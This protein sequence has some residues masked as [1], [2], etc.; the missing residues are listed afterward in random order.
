[1]RT[2]SAKDAKNH[3]G[4]LLLEAQKAPVTIEKNGR[5]V[6]VL[7]SIEEHEAAEKMKLE[8]LRSMI[9]EADDAI[10]RGEEFDWTDE[11]RRRFGPKERQSSPP[12]NPRVTEA[13]RVTLAAPARRDMAEIWSWIA[14]GNGI[15]RADAVLSRLREA[16]AVLAGNPMIGRERPDVRRA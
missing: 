16:C 10:A 13:R 11:F 5:P 1:M 4:E 15:R 3:F 9:A 6:A 14:V 8:R 2:M 7:L 12:L